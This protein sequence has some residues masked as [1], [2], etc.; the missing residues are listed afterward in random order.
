MLP[1]DPFPIRGRFQRLDALV[2]EAGL[3]KTT[4][5]A[6]KLVILEHARATVFQGLGHVIVFLM[7]Q[8]L[9]GKT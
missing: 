8:R 9:E 5:P 6:T 2:S 4:Q 1:L 3:R 7:V